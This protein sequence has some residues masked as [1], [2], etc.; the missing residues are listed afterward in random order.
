MAREQILDALRRVGKRVYERGKRADVFVFGGAV[1]VLAYQARPAT[2]DVDAVFEPDDEVLRAAAE[3]AAELGLPRYWLNNQG[4]SY[5]SSLR[6]ESSPV[7]LDEPGIRVMGASKDL[8][9]AMKLG[10]ARRE[11]DIEDIR[12]LLR[13]LKVASLEEAR[14]IFARFYPGEKLKDRAVLLVEDIL[15][16][17]G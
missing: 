4:S 2:R 13:E 17:N 6:G 3:V 5:L 8:A 11:Q 9:L 14:G 12:W 1:M 7:I 15:E 10:S 16:M